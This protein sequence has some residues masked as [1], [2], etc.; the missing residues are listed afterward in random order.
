MKRPALKRVST[1]FF[2][3]NMDQKAGPQSVAWALFSLKGRIRRATYGWG[4]AFIFCCWWVCISQGIALKEAGGDLG[5]WAIMT[6]V[7]VIASSYSLYALA[8]KR[9][10]D[11]GFRGIYALLYIPLSILASP[12]ATIVFFALAFF[13]GQEHENAFGPPPVL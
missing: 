9:L 6:G 13:P 7:V 5:F 2:V 8:H 4:F 11:L 10:H 1:T 3:T 12:I